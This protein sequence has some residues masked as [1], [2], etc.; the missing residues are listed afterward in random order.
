VRSE[1]TR[2]ALLNQ[3]DCLEQIRSMIHQAS[4]KPKGLSQDELLTIQIEYTK[5][6]L[7]IIKKIFLFLFNFKK[8]S[9]KIA[10]GKRLIDKRKISEKRSFRRHPVY[11]ASHDYY[12]K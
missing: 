3:A 2:K 12:G 4:F 11:D 8:K 6:F 7:E 1:K 10:D 5:L 9:K